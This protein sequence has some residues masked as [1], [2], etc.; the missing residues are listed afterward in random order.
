MTEAV[1]VVR[2]VITVA[3]STIPAQYILPDAM[4]AFCKSYPHA[5][6]R[7]ICCDSAG[8]ERLVADGEA[9][10]GMT[11]ALMSG[12]RCSWHDFAGDELVV[13]TPNT[14]QYSVFLKEGIPPE[15][16]LREPFIQRE[17]GSGTRRAYERFL[18]AAGINTEQMR[19]VAELEDPESVKRSVARGLGIS[20]LS[21]RAIEEFCR[22]VCCCP[23][24]LRPA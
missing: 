13:V 14:P 23:C 7:H 24:P 9:D 8:V 1:P 22:L 2:G 10:I 12:S 5:V 21:R 19:V 4:A 3:A 16:L 20:I 6:F 11:G 15:V 18:A 17:A